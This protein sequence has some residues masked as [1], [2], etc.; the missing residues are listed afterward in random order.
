[1][2]QYSL[3]NSAPAELQEGRM[4]KRLTDTALTILS[5]AAVRDNLRVLPVPASIKAPRPV[6][7]KTLDQLLHAGLIEVVPAAAE[8][9]AWSQDE[10]SGRTTLV[11]TPAGL[12]A[13]GMSD[14][15]PTTPTKATE[16]PSSGKGRVAAASVATTTARAKTAKSGKRVQ[17]D[18][19]PGGAA[20]GGSTKQDLVIALLRR[21]EG[22]S[23]SDMMEETGWQAHSVRG[24]MSG[25]LKNKLKLT[26]TS[27]KEDKTGERR[28]RIAAAKG[29]K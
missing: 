21:R 17:P 12:E 24:F 27:K 6:I 9:P 7:K 10:E 28:Y 23:I 14:E 19:S 18:K 16:R 20:G 5:S 29:G 13:I 2:W 1:L 11:L 3:G 26:V 4:T 8:D 25:A 15:H 22:A